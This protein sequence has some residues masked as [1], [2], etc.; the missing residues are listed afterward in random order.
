MQDRSTREGGGV[1]KDKDAMAW[2]SHNSYAGGAPMALVVYIRLVNKRPSSRSGCVSPWLESSKLMT[3]GFYSS[4]HSSRRRGWPW[5]DPA[6]SISTVVPGDH[7]H[8]THHPEPQSAH[9]YAMHDRPCAT[10]AI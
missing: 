4:A 1:G 6:W 5:E 2:K 8:F 3:I 7:G 10:T 9:S